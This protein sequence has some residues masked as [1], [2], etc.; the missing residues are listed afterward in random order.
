MPYVRSAPADV[1]LQV[2][3]T[4]GRRKTITCPGAFCRVLLSR[5]GYELPAHI[6]RATWTVALQYFADVDPPPDAFRRA[7]DLRSRQQHGRLDGGG[8][9]A[10]YLLA[11][12]NLYLK[13]WA[14]A[15]SRRD[16]YSGV[17]SVEFT[18]DDDDDEAYREI[19]EELADL[20]DSFARSES[21]G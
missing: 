7:L 20:T 18:Y 11:Q 14:Q 1:V 12:W 16:T 17:G 4:S 15:Q 5:G 10:S 19:N 13:G 6:N 3:L 8:R 21:S 9:V 2:R